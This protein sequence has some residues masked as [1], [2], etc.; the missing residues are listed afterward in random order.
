MNALRWFGAKTGSKSE[1]SVTANPDWHT[2]RAGAGDRAGRKIRKIYAVS[3][4]YVIYFVGS[5]VY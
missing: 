5:E 1:E 3:D 4:D 2:Y